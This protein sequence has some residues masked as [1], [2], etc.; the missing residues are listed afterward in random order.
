VID[1][2]ELIDTINISLFNAMANMHTSTVCRVEN[3]NQKTIDVKPV[4]NRVV[5]GRSIELTTFTKVI[6]LFMKGG[7]S[8]TAHPI[9]VG[10]YCLVIFTERCLDRWY[11]GQDFV[12]PAEFR[13]HDYSDGIAIVGLENFSGSIDIPSIIKQVGD[14]NIVGDVTIDGN[15]TVN[16]DINCTGRVTCENA[17]IAGI[18]FAS[19]V[20]GGVQTGGGNTGAPS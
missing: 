10:D 6:P 17:T 2:K 3:V 8:Y 18:D 13:M 1:K 5:K 11:S 14:T 4:V 7:S 19:H 20:H 9:S 15:L 16:G 12:E